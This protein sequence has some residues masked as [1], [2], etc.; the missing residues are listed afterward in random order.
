MSIVTEKVSAASALQSQTC[1]I[2][3]VQ[4]RLLAQH[5]PSSDAVSTDE[6]KTQK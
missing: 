2:D 4:S 6:Y 3:F 5:E 1:S